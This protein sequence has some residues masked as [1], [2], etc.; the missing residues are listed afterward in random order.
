MQTHGPAVASALQ[1]RL[2]PYDLCDATVL[3]GLNER[4]TYMIQALGLDQPCAARTAAALS[5]V[6]G[7]APRNWGIPVKLSGA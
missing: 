5:R 2:A 4:V 1:A 3:A 6:R 7:R